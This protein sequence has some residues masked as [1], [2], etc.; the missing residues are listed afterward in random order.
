MI[1]TEGN[2]L[3]E[4]LYNPPPQMDEDEKWLRG[5]PDPPTEFIKATVEECLVYVRRARAE[6]IRLEQ[7]NLLDPAVSVIVPHHFWGK[8][9]T[10]AA[11]RLRN[12]IVAVVTE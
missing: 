10:G 6:R 2:K 11:F 3:L 12:Y 1:D 9:L 7:V 8:K 5:I 4:I